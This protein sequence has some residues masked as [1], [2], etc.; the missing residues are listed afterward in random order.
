MSV[1]VV[2]LRYA[3][4][5]AL[6]LVVFARRLVHYYQGGKVVC[7][8]NVNEQSKV[9]LWLLPILTRRRDI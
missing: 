5:H 7:Q 6:S 8:C 9:L 3:R 2:L 1:Y 4:M